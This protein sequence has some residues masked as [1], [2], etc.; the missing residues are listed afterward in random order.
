MRRRQSVSAKRTLAIV[1]G[2]VIAL[3]VAFAATYPRFHP[4]QAAVP[5]PAAAASTSPANPVGAVVAAAVSAAG[6][7]A[8]ARLSAEQHAALAP[9]KAD[10]DRFSTVR[11]R[12][13]L[14]IA[15]HYQ[16]MTPEAQKRLHER[17]GAWTG[18]SPNQRRLARENYQLSRH[19]PPQAREKAWRAYQKLPDDQKRKLA[20]S[21]TPRRPNI[22]S[23]PPSGKTEIKDINRLVRSR[24]RRNPVPKPAAHAGGPARPAPAKVAGASAGAAPPAPAMPASSLNNYQAQ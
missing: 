9:F 17:M 6:P 22:V 13:W 11:K 19:V 2:C 16:H 7:L 14:K 3:V 10:W 1:S 24:E 20:A 23:A 21:G 4:R 15:A 5:G 8:W 12:K 18:M